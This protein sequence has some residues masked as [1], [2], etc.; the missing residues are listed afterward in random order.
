MVYCHK[1]VK[2]KCKEYI[3]DNLQLIVAVFKKKNI[4]N[5]KKMVVLHQLFYIFG[6][7]MKLVILVQFILFFEKLAFA[8]SKT[9]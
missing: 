2:A 7:C 9:A 4:I 8:Y 6:E 1:I 3:F 5:Y